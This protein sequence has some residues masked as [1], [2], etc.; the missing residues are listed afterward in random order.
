V[1]DFRYERGRGR[2]LS[3]HPTGVLH[4]RRGCAE[5]QRKRDENAGA[6]V[7]TGE[8]WHH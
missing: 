5:K 1:P 8:N 2:R 4:E 6:L 3:R 7:R